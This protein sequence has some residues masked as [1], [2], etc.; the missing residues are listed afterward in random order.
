ML[1]L[2][3]L[4]HW[5]DFKWEFWQHKMDYTL[6]LFLINLTL[7]WLRSF[8]QKVWFF[9]LL[10]IASKTGKSGEANQRKINIS[11]GMSIVLFPVLLFVM[12]F[13]TVTSTPMLPIFSLPFFILTFP[14]TRRMWPDAEKSLKSTSNA[15]WVFYQQMTPHLQRV[16]SREFT[17]GAL[18]NSNAG[19]Y[20]LVRFQDRIIWISVLEHGFLYD[21]LAVKGLELQE[22]S[23]HSTEAQSID[24]LFLSDDTNNKD[25]HFFNRNFFHILTPITNLKMEV[26]SD[27][28]NVLT[29]I[30]DNRE[31]LE[32]MSSTFP[33]VLLWESMKLFKRRRELGFEEPTTSS[34]VEDMNNMYNL[35]SDVEDII[36]DEPFQ[37]PQHLKHNMM[38]E[39]TVFTSTYTKN[40]SNEEE[41]E[42]ED[43]DD[44]FGNFGFGDDEYLE[45]SIDG[46]GSRHLDSHHIISNDHDDVVSNHNDPTIEPP[47]NWMNTAPFRDIELI[48]INKHFDTTYYHAFIDLLFGEY[49]S[50][51]IKS[52]TSLMQSY[53]S[54]ILNCYFLVE[55][56]GVPDN[57]VMEEGASH[58]YRMFSGKLPWSPRLDWIQENDILKELIIKSYRLVVNILLKIHLRMMTKYT[59]SKIMQDLNLKIMYNGE[60]KLGIP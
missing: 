42:E 57:S 11:L 37:P 29:G 27:A 22:T 55:K 5:S 43:E 7:T 6:K 45:D 10:S 40:E 18:S 25:D 48:S 36:S 4:I 21:H 49:E 9:I 50:A 19:D 31:F 39:E 35:K 32:D 1:A 28:K 47:Q 15:D 56:G 60:S 44:E 8:L 51:L 46:G 17:S 24:D 41:E 13:S 20:L 23:C 30:I 53:R 16:L 12:V 26:Y 33:K 52:D 3:T 34:V 2:Y 14:R 54:F 58:C 59:T 38:V